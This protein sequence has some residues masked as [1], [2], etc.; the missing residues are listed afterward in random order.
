MPK[1]ELFE[2]KRLE[3]QMERTVRFIIRQVFI[4]ADEYID[5]RRW[6]LFPKQTEFSP[7]RS[8]IFLT[9]AKF[10]EILLP[11]IIEFLNDE[12]IEDSTK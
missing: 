2:N 12:N 3:I 1:P 4:G 11:K 7:T 5:V 9:K 8:G 10:K 6:L